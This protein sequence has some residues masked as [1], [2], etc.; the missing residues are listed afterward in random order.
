MRLAIGA[1]PLA[2][3]RL[4]LASLLRPVLGGLA[5]GLLVA[6]LLGRFMSGLLFGVSPADPISFL[7]VTVLIVTVA[8]AATFVPLRRAMKIAPLAALRAE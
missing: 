6:A 7:A 2:I 1:N 4:V 8:V 5:V 3:I